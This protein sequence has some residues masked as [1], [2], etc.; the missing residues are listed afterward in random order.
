MNERKKNNII[1]NRF[2]LIFLTVIDTILA[3]G[4]WQERNNGNLSK[5]F[6]TFLVGV[7]LVT[8]VID[9]IVFLNNKDSDAFR[10]ISIIGYGIAYTLSMIAASNDMVFTYAFP[11][12]VVYIL[13]FD[14]AFF[15]RSGI[16]VNVVNI[17]TVIYYCIRGTF[18]S[19]MPA[20]VS[21]AMIQIFAVAVTVGVVYFMIRTTNKLGEVRLGLLNA[22]QQKTTEMLDHILK[23]ASVVKENSENANAIITEWDETSTSVTT[24]L[25]DIAVGNQRTAESIDS[26]TRMTESIQSMIEQTKENSDAMK[27]LAKEGMEAI[28]DGKQSILDLKKKAERIEESNRTVINSM[29][30]L[31]QNSSEVEQITKAI[32]DISSQTNLLA[33]NASIESAR[34]GEAGKGFA[35]VAE[36]IRLLADQTRTLTENIKNIVTSLQSNADHAQNVVEEVII[37]TKEEQTLINI[38]DDKFKAI[39]GNM[40]SLNQNVET[41]Y[42]QVNQMLTS[43][44]EIVESI[45]SISE[46][47]NEVAAGTQQAVAIGHENNEKARQTKQLMRE[48]VQQAEQLNKYNQSQ[49]E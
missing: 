45:T 36:E 5:S 16:L 26:Q 49:E 14:E 4:Y 47:S 28:E 46:V 10:H 3:I 40:N 19:G 21:L 43:N 39:Q 9:W 27:E 17:G 48:L 6:A 20:S 24:M 23:V 12:I 1:A 37:A 32:F 42:E 11:M 41:I 34:A 22:E 31:I 8:L 29:V 7:F 35:V 13:Y 44:D 33:L 25:D 15:M 18:P 30:T 2:V 38:A